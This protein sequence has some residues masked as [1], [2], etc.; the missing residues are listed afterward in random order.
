MVFLAQRYN[1]NGWTEPQYPIERND[2]QFNQ[3]S[4]QNHDKNLE[5]A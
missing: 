2:S 3:I 4:K 1:A 5:I